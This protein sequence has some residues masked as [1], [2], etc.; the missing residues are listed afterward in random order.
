MSKLDGRRKLFARIM[1]W[2]LSALMAGS[3]GL[4]LISLIIEMTSK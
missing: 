3:C 1:A 4:L 2:T